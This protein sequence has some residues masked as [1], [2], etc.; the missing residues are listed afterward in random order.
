[1]ALT[2][3]LLVPGNAEEMAN[4]YVEVF[5]DG[6]LKD[7]FRIPMPDGSRQTVMANI[8][9]H[10][11]DILLINGTPDHNTEFTEAFSLTINAQNQQDVDYF[12]DKFVGDGGQEVACGWCRDKFGVFWQVIPTEMPQLLQDPDP[13]RAAAAFTAM[14]NMVKID[15]NA[16]KAAMDSGR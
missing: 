1:M 10:G 6:E 14:S 3:S 5:P 11:T 2:P 16:V 8:R 4:Y 13:V 9:V 12:W 7:I 15:I